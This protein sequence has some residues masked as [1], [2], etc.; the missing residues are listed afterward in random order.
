MIWF[1]LFFLFVCRLLVLVFGRFPTITSHWTK[2]KWINRFETGRSS[3]WPMPLHYLT[4]I[5]NCLSFLLFTTVICCIAVALS[6]SFFLCVSHFG[7]EA[8]RQ[9]HRYKF[10]DAKQLQSSRTQ[11]VNKMQTTK[12]KIQIHER[13][14]IPVVAAISINKWTCFETILRILSVTCVMQSDFQHRL[15]ET[16]AHTLININYQLIWQSLQSQIISV[17]CRTVP[18]WLICQ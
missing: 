4:L 10:C 7:F 13:N 18:F 12:Y 17:R 9:I 8:A 15:D 2:T 5:W 11:C 16:L 1:S 6:L 14:G 3:H